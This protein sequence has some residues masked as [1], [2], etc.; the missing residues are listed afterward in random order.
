MDHQS[1]GMTGTDDSEAAIREFVDGER[2][3]MVLLVNFEA[4]EVGAGALS[5]KASCVSTFRGG[6]RAELN[7][8]KPTFDLV[9]RSTGHVGL[10]SWQILA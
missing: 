7:V 6:L 3:T 2:T 1:K 5:Q 4:V 9:S 8:E 10:H